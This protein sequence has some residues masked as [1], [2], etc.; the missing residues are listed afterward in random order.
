MVTNF[1]DLTVEVRV[2]LKKLVAAVP[3]PFRDLIG[4]D[5]IEAAG[6]RVT[7]T[8]VIAPLSSFRFLPD[9]PDAEKFASDNKVALAMQATRNTSALRKKTLP[10][11]T[12]YGT[13]LTAL[14]EAG[15]TFD[16]ETFSVVKPKAK[17]KPKTAPA[18]KQRAKATA[19]KKKA[20]PAAKKAAAKA[21]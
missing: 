7:K 2:S 6:A 16:A 9:D 5:V 11:P 17:A 18:P 1:K 14:D 20:A 4:T 12:G 21:K 8:Q 3:A 10:W 19:T 13:L 15:A